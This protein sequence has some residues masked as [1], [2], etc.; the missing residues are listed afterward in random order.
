MDRQQVISWEEGIWIEY[1]Y[2]AEKFDRELP[3]SILEEISSTVN[4]RYRGE[5]IAYSSKLRSLVWEH[6]RFLRMDKS[7]ER[8]PFT[9]LEYLYNSLPKKYLTDI[10]NLPRPQ[11]KEGTL[12]LWRENNE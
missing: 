2:L 11:P 7:A 4:P 1:Y 10:L 6:F 9:K 5:S 3:G 8:Y 12:N